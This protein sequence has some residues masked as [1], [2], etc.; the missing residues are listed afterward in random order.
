MTSVEKVRAIQELLAR[1]HSKDL[2]VPECK[3]GPTIWTSHSRIDGLAMKKSWSNLVFDGY[4]IKVSRSDFMNDDKWHA[5]LP[6]CNRLWFVCPSGLIQPNEVPPETGLMWA[7]KNYTRLYRKKMAQHRKEDVD[8]YT[9]IYILMCRATV[10]KESAVGEISAYWRHWLD[11][12]KERKHLGHEVSVAIREQ[13]RK[14]QDEN[15]RLVRQAEAVESVKQE[16][17]KCGI[18]VEKGNWAWEMQKMVISARDGMSQWQRRDL[19][20]AVRTLQALLATAEE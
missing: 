20:R 4:E 8:Q 1:K 3:N 17:A 6:M 15:D 10:Q 13:V 2:Y 18:D 12:K 19:E 14:T 7:S 9:L 11:E 16:C 5:Y